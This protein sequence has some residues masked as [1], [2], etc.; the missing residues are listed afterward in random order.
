MCARTQVHSLCPY[1]NIYI[2]QQC[3]LHDSRGIRRKV[4]DLTCFP[5]HWYTRP[6]TPRLQMDREFVDRKTWVQIP[7]QPG[8]RTPSADDT[9]T[10]HCAIEVIKE[11]NTLKS[12]KIHRLPSLSRRKPT[13]NPRILKRFQLWEPVHS[14]YPF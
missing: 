9:L 11:S 10:N 14:C 5:R 1:H 3:E 12:I 2:E 7:A 8:A 13:S 4:Y 6:P